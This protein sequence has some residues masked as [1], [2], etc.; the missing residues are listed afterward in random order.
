MPLSPT[1]HACPGLV[2]T[3]HSDRFEPSEVTSCSAHAV[4]FQWPIFAP[5]APQTSLV[6]SA[7]MPLKIAPAFTAVNRASFGLE[8]HTESMSVVGPVTTDQLWPSK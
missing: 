3:D 2:A 8:A 7:D 1:T 4:P 5:P 6:D